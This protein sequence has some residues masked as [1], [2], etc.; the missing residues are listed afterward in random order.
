MPTLVASCASLLMHLIAYSHWLNNSAV[1]PS[2]ASVLVRFAELR[3][4]MNDRLSRKTKNLVSCSVSFSRSFVKLVS[5][6]FKAR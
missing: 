4:S 2:F 3:T 5:L 1:I 6:E